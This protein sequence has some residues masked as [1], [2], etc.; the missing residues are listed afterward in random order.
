MQKFI[1]AVLIALGSL[2]PPAGAQSIWVKPYQPVQFSVEAIQPNFGDFYVPPSASSEI[3]L[4]DADPGTDV[5]TGPLT[6]AVFVSGTYA[7]SPGIALSA[8]LP[9][10]HYSAEVGERS[11]SETAIGNPY[12][13][14]GLSSTSFPLLLELGVR[15]PL[16]SGDNPAL[17]A[18]SFADFSRG[19]AFAPDMLSFEALF[20][21][22]IQ[23]SDR[24]NTRLRA[25]PVFQS[26]QGSGGTNEFLTRYSAQ[27][28]FEGNRLT[29]GAGASGRAFLTE[30]GSF[31]EVTDHHVAGTLLVHI[32]PLSPGILFATP[33]GGDLRDVADFFFGVSLSLSF[34]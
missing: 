4:A 5:D 20:N 31:E 9:I 32:G 23:L 11:T 10:A 34:E 17:E 7:Y 12:I 16:A 27:L 28:W 18:S 30:S 21:A 19:E 13:G 3:S 2:A 15:L 25:G 33:L 8:E 1:L 29:F 22:R 24:I 14:V 6:S 26:D